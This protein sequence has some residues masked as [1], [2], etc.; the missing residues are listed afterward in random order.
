[1]STDTF[2]YEYYCNSSNESMN[3]LE[4]FRDT[5]HPLLGEYRKLLYR[6]NVYLSLMKSHMAT[7]ILLHEDSLGK[8]FNDRIMASIA[9]HIVKNDT[10]IKVLYIRMTKKKTDR[11][12]YCKKYY[13]E[14][15]REI[16]A[17]HRL[18]D[19][20]K[21]KRSHPNNE[22]TEQYNFQHKER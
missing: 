19:K 13:D 2:N 12:A 17:R 7:S 22:Y 16:A 21:Y 3:T 10:K 4:M 5:N 9:S 6:Q 14:H 18:Y 1:M 11:K 8:A 20:S 15:R